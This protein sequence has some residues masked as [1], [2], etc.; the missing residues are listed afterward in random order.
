MV[1]KKKSWCYIGEEELPSSIVSMRGIDREKYTVINQITNETIEEV[2]ASKAFFQVYE[3][4]VYIHQG[5]NNTWSKLWT[6]QQR[7]HLVFR[8]M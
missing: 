3:G 4:A 1:L 7:W 8:L 6:L 5:Q 2:E